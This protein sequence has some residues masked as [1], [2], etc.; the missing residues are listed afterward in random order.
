MPALTPRPG[1]GARRSAGRL[2]ARVRARPVRSAALLYAVLSL[3]MVSPGLAPGRTLSSS[4]YLWTAAPWLAERPPGVRPGGANVELADS[5]SN[6]QP[7]LRYTRDALP[8]IPLWNPHIMAGRPFL[9][10][11]Q[12][13]VFSPFSV[14]AYVLPFWLS[15]GVIGAL[16]LFVAAFGTF[17]LG[18][19]LGMHDAGAL[20]AGL[21]FGLSLDMVEWLA[22]P[23][24][25][26]WAFLP[27]LLLLADRVARAPSPLPAAGLA[28]VTALQFVGGHPESSFH[29]LFA[30][31]AFFLL[32]LVLVRRAAGRGPPAL[33]RSLSAF[34]VALAGGAALAAVAIAPFAELLLHSADLHQR[35]GVKEVGLATHY[36][37]AL[38]LPDYWGRPG[39]H[40]LEA[41][42]N[43]RALYLGALPLLLGAVALVLRP[44]LERLAVAG[45]AAFSLLLVFA[46]TPIAHLVESLPGFNTAHNARVIILFV[47][48]GALLAGW[49]LS[50]L[51]R[52][53]P[54]RRR[55]AA[56]A[57]AAV[58]V[59]APLVWV[60][61]RH[62]ET[63]RSLARAFGLAWGV[64]RIGDAEP[65]S[66]I[67]WSALAAWIPLA[68]AALALL[69]WRLSGRLAA[70]PFATL[71]VALVVLD[72]FR[73]GLGQNPAI[74]RAAAAQPT[75]GALR[76]LQ[77]RRPA[78]FVGL[79][80][81]RGVVPIPPNAAMDYGLYDARGYDYPVEQRY[82]RLWRRRVASPDIF[83]PPTTLA[84]TG[85]AALRALSL[86][87][88]ADLVQ[89][90]GSPRLS[91]PGLRLAYDGPDARVYA[92]DRALPRV[93]VA[94]EQE[95]VR[96]GDAALAA[97]TRAGFDAARTVVA[98][99]PIAGIPAAGATPA[100]GPAGTASLSHYGRERVRVSAEAKRP[101]VLVLTD[102]SFPGWRATV[103]G[104]PAQ[105]ERVDYLLRG[106]AI[107][108]G[109][110][111]VE[112]RYEP[113]SWRI[114]WIVS[115]VALVALVAAAAL[116]ARSARRGGG[117]A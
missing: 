88:V 58:L 73:T 30:T 83:A 28:G 10:D 32:R 43:Q 78:R 81:P 49:G 75:T 91:G 112:L 107:G 35:S 46:K 96:G 82:D 114:G 89:Q 2:A 22:W 94:G 63:P 105:L 71:A 44:G 108:P 39:Q 111:T 5:V 69:A 38:M 101:G 55:A 31:C 50:D 19:A 64:D 115:A 1:S 33:I 117:R 42:V 15:L 6:F 24:P 98:E 47:M 74:A 76:Y 51:L 17:L 29:V 85:P 62:P 110:H 26:V 37:A 59:V 34:A 99:H 18:R 103:D 8:D 113:A 36:L 7:S 52:V 53:P 11:A 23:L 25:S 87:S 67:H 84:S 79:P 95:V 54:D 61:L 104:R 97:A 57:A 72:L 80:P 4:D 90:P 21:C 65:P 56:L 92:N 48:C 86:L 100:P 77:A 41:F 106:V 13:A 60:A 3:A 116:G 93:F 9:A 16:K 40:V 70:A 20:L 102:A 12:S 45:F 14:P 109:P 66:N 68:G 27:W